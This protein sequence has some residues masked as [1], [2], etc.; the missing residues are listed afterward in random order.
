MSYLPSSTLPGG[1]SISGRSP[2]AVNIY[3]TA[4]STERGSEAAAKEDEGE[5]PSNM[6]V[7]ISSHTNTS[8]HQVGEDSLA[9]AAADNEHEVTAHQR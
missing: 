3:S 5:R 4:P 7:T 8:P 6:A 1:S 9:I 2:A